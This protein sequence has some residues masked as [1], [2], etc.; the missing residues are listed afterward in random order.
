MKFRQEWIASYLPGE[1]PGTA[2][3]KERLTAVGFVVETAEGDGPGA[4]LDVEITANRPDAMNHRGLAREAAVALRREFRDPEAG[5]GVVETTTPVDTL[6]KVL[7]EE[8]LLCDRYSARVIEGIRVGPSGSKLGDRL[9]A[10]DAGLISG[11]VDSTNHVLWDIGQPL[12]AFDLDKLE[13]GPDGLPT[14]IVRRSRPGEKLVTI[15]GVERSLSPEHLVIADAKKA[16]ALAGIMGGLETA[17]SER[18]TRILLESAHFDPGVVRRGAKLLGMHTD[19]SHRF[20]RGTDPEATIEGLD[21]AA[22]LL[23]SDG[24]GTVAR[25][26]ID[27]RPAKRIARSLTLRITHLHAFLGIA[28]PEVRCEEIL[29]ELGFSPVTRDGTLRVAVPSWRVDVEVEVDLVEEV[30]RCEGYDRLP[31]T[32]PAPYVPAKGKRAFAFEDRVRDL[33]VAEGLFEASTYSFVSEGE[34]RPF[35]AAAPGAPVVLENPLAEP[36]ATMRATPVLGLLQS[37]QHNVRRGIRDL[38]LFEI[39]HAYGRIGTA[40]SLE[41]RIREE[42][43]AT[44][45]LTGTRRHHWSEEPRPVDFFD[46]SGAVAALFRGLA[47]PEPSFEPISLPFLAAQRAAAVVAAD[48]CR[49]GWVGVLAAPLSAAWDLLD[50]VVADLDLGLLAERMPPPPVSVEP[51]PKLP[52]SDVDVTVTHALTVPW[53]ELAER[54]RDGAPAELLAVEAK[55]RYRGAGV[56]DGFVKTTMTLRFGSPLRSLAREEIN[57]WRDAAAGRLL[58][59]KETKVD[60]IPGPGA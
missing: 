19:A 10:L 53:R 13:K 38:G 16:V 17:I 11:P 3:L 54:V 1:P 60:G 33:L 2:N 12:H 48:G 22:R 15:D 20:E 9:A 58:A 26:V 34:N 39:G 14:I 41:E 24:G 51:P 55:G 27:V 40:G 4:V 44:L 45:L 43:R 18:T 47:L 46:G 6:A 5:R 21:R 30:I 28:I 42:R 32:L 49:L 52:G 36:F 7:V 37:A 25:G 31:E 59:M 56:P 57:G 50:P 23:V 29:R 35:E 8:P